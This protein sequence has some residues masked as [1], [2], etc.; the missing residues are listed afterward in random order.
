MINRGL[1]LLWVASLA[2]VVVLGPGCSDDDDAKEDVSSSTDAADHD[3]DGVSHEEHADHEGDKGHDTDGTGAEQDTADED[4]AEADG[5]AEVGMAGSMG[6]TKDSG[7]GSSS[8]A[9]EEAEGEAVD[10]MAPFALRFSVVSG[11]TEVGCTEPLAGLGVDGAY[12]L[13]L[14]DLRFYLSELRFLDADGKEVPMELDFG[15]NAFQYQN[16]TGY[17]AMVDLTGNSEGSCL[18]GVGTEE[19]TSATHPAVTGLT[20]LQQVAAV[21]FKVGVPQPLMKDIINSN[22]PESAPA[23]LY[24]LQWRWAGGYRH[25]V[26]N[27]RVIDA[28]GAEGG[29]FLHLGSSGCTATDGERALESKDTCDRINTPEV[30]IADFDVEKDVVAVDLGALVEGLDFVAPILD[31]ETFEPIGEGPGVACHSGP[32]QPDCETVFGAFGLDLA[33]GAADAAT[34]TVFHKR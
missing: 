8:G 31:S 9:D 5:V 26:F 3:A 29:A 14:S 16:D 33:T 15:D 4:V 10:E 34:N 20:H 19:A 32:M 30:A 21:E 27:G 24:Q 7:G 11:D 6:D 13:H 22:T 28:E 25:F 23:P 12:T 17:V 2:V 18:E 1:G